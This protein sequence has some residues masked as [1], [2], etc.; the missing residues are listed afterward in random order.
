M[1]ADLSHM[2]RALVLA[3]QGLYTTQPNPRVG[4]VIVKDGVVVGEGFHAR[5]GESHAEVHALRQAGE[6]ARGATAYVTLE[7][8]SHHGRTPPCADALVKA[9]VARVVAAMQDPNPLVGG[10]GLAKLHAAGIETACGVLENEARALNPGFLRRIAGGLPWV[11]VKLAMS[12]DGRTAMASGESQ[13]ITGPAARRDVQKLRAQSGAIITGVGTVLADDPSMTVRTADWLDW[14][15][16]VAPVQPLRVIVDGGL[17][18]PPTAKILHQPG[19]VMIATAPIEEDRV[20]DD[21]AAMLAATGAE[22]CELP[23]QGRHIML[24]ALLEKLRDAQINEILVEAGPTL[25]GAFVAA[26]LV[27]ELIVYQAPTLLG[28]TAMPLLELPLSRMAE[29]RRLQVLDRR[30]VGDDLRWTLAFARS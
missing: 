20:A 2:A 1:S 8:C 25:A 4:C 15:E 26:D 9:G 16:G 22:I 10:Q 13:W 29:Q 3:R 23:T 7:P 11:R 18:T 21:R 6:L 19:Q 17:Q 5:A 14:P 27:D 12:L 30:A 28:S 24:R